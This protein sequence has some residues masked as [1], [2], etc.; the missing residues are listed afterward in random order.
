MHFT[1]FLNYLL[2]LQIIKLLQQEKLIV[3][4]IEMI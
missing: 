3:G 2:I 1:V 4:E